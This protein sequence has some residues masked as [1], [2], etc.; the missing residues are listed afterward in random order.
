MIN[1]YGYDI[2]GQGLHVTI[3]ILVLDPRFECMDLV[4]FFWY[5]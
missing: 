5:C 3:F 2:F 4:S 1:R